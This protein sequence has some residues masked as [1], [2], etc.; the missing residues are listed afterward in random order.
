MKKRALI[1]FPKARW[2]AG[3][4]SALEDRYNLLAAETI[5][6]A[7]ELAPDCEVLIALAPRI[8][9]RLVAAMPRLEWIHALTTGYENLLAMDSLRPEVA[10]SNS[11][12]IHGPQM[13]ELAILL[14][15]SLSR[16][17]T[18]MMRNQQS[19]SWD[20]WDQPLLFQKT[21]CIVGVGVI[22]EG[23]AARCGPFGMRVTG[24]S[25]GRSEVAG[26]DHIYPRRAIRDAVAEADFVVVV[27]PHSP[28]THH[29]INGDVISAM[30]PSGILVNI[31]RGGC[32]DEDA[33]VDH[34]R[35]GTIAGAG[36][37]VFQTEP[38]PKDSPFWAMP[39]VVITPHIG[40]MSDIYHEQVLPI[41][42]D[43]LDRY[44]REGARGLIN[45]VDR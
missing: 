10:L 45:R 8:P 39:N 1:F 22:G 6:E 43:N 17:A 5:D 2:M 14:M 28:E 44:D 16:N 25:D 36:L 24:V 41:V 9:D 23:L 21:V 37:D 40:G 20:R 33:L 19:A 32:V 15:M 42:A 38:L 11:R 35:A 26:F 34:L 12:G 18:Q 30:K 3:Q 4:L 29:I 13:A 27:V 31:A 7:M